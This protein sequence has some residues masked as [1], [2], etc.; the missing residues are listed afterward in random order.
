LRRHDMRPLELLRKRAFWAVDFLKGGSIR[1]HYND[2]RFILENHSSPESVARRFRYLRGILDHAVET[3][4]VYRKHQGFKS[5]S[6]FPVIN[7][8]V[9]RGNFEQFRSDAYR[10]KDL[11]RAVTSGSTGMPFSIYQDKNKRIRNSV[12]TLYFANRANFEVGSRLVYLKIWCEENRKTGLT[13]W[14]QNVL[15]HNVTNMADRDIARLIDLLQKDKSTK[16]LLGFPSGYDAIC[17]YLDRQNSGPLN[18][19]VTSIIAMSESLSE[20]AK[21]S[22]KKYFSAPVVSR[23]SNLECGILSQQ[24]N[25]EE[26]EFHINTASYFVEV[27]DLEKD[28]PIRCGEP[29]R[30]VVTDLFNYA[31]P[32][33]R[34]DTGDIGVLSEESACSF[35][36]PVFTR[37]QG[38][39]TD[40]I[41]DTR[42]G[43]LSPVVVINTMMWKYQELKQYQFI[44]EGQKSYAFKLNVDKEFTRE[45]ELIRE[46]KGILGED[47]AIRTEY[48]DEIPVLSSGKRKQV[49]NCS[50]RIADRSL[51]KSTC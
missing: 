20:Y 9:I 50:I 27:L 13:A 38:R 19:N 7:K 22:M 25:G 5:L 45:A 18:C 36:T 42:G 46:F 40:S 37:V 39:K 8:S 14:L 29:G 3:T 35:K 1:R 48:V 34:Y 11:F 43:L 21:A 24:C 16:G 26:N 17:R 44:Q 32:M 23:Y 41:Y 12:D 51:Q 28:E 31:M 47:A 10:G 2:I 6:D 4:P 30:I 49:V 15:M 33:I